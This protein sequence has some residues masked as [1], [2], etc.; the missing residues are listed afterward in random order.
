LT[1]NF[2][3]VT[4]GREDI[5]YLRNYLFL[6]IGQVDKDNSSIVEML[7]KGILVKRYD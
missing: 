1:D 4:F 3:S 5:Q 7:E 2:L 6:I